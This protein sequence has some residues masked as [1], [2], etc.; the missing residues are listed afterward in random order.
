MKKYEVNYYDPSTGATSP[1]DVIEAPEGCTAEQY[2][3]DC[4]EYADDDWNQMLDSGVVTLV[5]VEG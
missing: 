1:I 5:E 2:V 4:A 3:A